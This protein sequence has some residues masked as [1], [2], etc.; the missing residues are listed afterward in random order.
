VIEKV[1]TRGDD[2]DRRYKVCRCADCDLVE[3]CTPTR[4][5][6]TRAPDRDGPLVCEPCL[7]ATRKA[8]N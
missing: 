8:A 7:L 6:Y 2:G 4:D 1:F 5:F 3:L